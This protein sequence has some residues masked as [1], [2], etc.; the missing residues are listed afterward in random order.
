MQL[1]HVIGLLSTISARFC[2][3]YPYLFK[4]DPIMPFV[5]VYVKGV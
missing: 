3:T 1:T 2:K 4:A 5:L